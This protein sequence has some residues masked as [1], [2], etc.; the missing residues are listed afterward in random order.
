[1]VVLEEVGVR[2]AKARFSELATMANANGMAIRVLRHNKPWVEIV[3]LEQPASSQLTEFDQ[4]V[5]SLESRS[6]AP[7]WPE[8]ASDKD[9]LNEERMRR[10]G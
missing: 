8:G 4:F 10:F 3:P 9:L 7:A 5:A 2:E 6:L 1:M